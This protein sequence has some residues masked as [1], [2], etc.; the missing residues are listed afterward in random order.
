MDLVILGLDD[1][2]NYT[3]QDTAMGFSSTASILE[4]VDDF[5]SDN[6]RMVISIVDFHSPG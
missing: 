4:L 2:L 6:W 3:C 5:I 1:V